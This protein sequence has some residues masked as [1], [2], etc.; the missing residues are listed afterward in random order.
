M[1]APEALDAHAVGSTGVLV[2]VSPEARLAGW[3]GGRRVVDHGAGSRAVYGV[4]AEP[5]IPFV[6]SVHRTWDCILCTPCPYGLHDSRDLS[7]VPTMSSAHTITS[8]PSAS[9]TA[10]LT[11][12]AALRARRARRA[13]AGG[14]TRLL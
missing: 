14:H 6:P 7:I 12:R 10:G 5:V 4:E 3:S 8:V 9:L 1:P 11:R 13:P 2:R